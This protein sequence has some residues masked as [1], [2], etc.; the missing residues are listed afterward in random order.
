MSLNG[1]LVNKS[2]DHLGSLET[3]LNGLLKPVAPRPEFVNTL[4]QRIKI[5]EQPAWVSRFNNMQFI[6]ILVTGVISGV[7][8]VTMLARALLNILVSGKKSSGVS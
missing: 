7:V 8:I 4:R 5:T 2:N 1:Q 3:K 6:L